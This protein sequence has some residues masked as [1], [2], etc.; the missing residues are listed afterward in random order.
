MCVSES[1]KK[2]F[3]FGLEMR[4]EQKSLCGASVLLWLK[5]SAEKGG[6]SADSTLMQFKHDSEVLDEV[7]KA[8]LCM[9]EKWSRNDEAYHPFEIRWTRKL[10]KAFGETMVWSRTV[11]RFQ[12]STEFDAFQPCTWTVYGMFSLASPMILCYQV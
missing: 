2:Q 1:C 7:D 6:K 8:P 4:I 9:R 10:S 5:T 12:G 3:W 11:W